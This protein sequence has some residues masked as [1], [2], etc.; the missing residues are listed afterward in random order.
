MSGNPIR[1]L[2]VRKTRDAR[3]QTAGRQR[4]N[5]ML[6]S[7]GKQRLVETG[8]CFVHRVSMPPLEADLVDLGIAIH[9]AERATL[10]VQHGTA[11]LA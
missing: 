7:G 11:L 8:W 6:K 3:G 10:I 1:R 9:L 2:R 5:Q 4:I